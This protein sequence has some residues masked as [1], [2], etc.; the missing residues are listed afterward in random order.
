MSTL[1]MRRWYNIMQPSTFFHVPI[2]TVKASIAVTHT[3]L[4]FSRGNRRIKE[5]YNPSYTY[6]AAPLF[7]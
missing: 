2:K 7:F 6:N 1:E 5:H 4:E 3:I